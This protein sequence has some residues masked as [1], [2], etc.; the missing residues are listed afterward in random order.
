MK[1]K[2]TN[3]V[4]KVTTY[5]FAWEKLFWEDVRLVDHPIPVMVEINKQLVPAWRGG[6]R[7]SD[8][9]DPYARHD[10]CLMVAFSPEQYA[11]VDFEYIY[12]PSPD[13]FDMYFRERMGW[14]KVTQREDVDQVVRLVLLDTPICNVFNA[15]N[16]G[17]TLKH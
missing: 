17:L 11:W 6:F 13:N 15:H 8:V 9:H 10:E 1:N 7:L 3:I 4:P 12:K 2:A 5:S 14:Y 16:Y